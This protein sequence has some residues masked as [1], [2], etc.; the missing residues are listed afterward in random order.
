[1]PEH[2]DTTSDLFDIPS[3]GLQSSQKISE[4]EYESLDME[5]KL[6]LELQSIGISPEPMVSHFPSNFH[7]IFHASHSGK[8]EHYQV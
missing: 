2:D 1:M 3:N 7:A 4:L 5:D 6:L 8:Y